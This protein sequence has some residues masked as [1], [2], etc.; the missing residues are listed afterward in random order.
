[1]FILD[2]EICFY[3]DIKIEVK[4]IGN[5]I[6][7]TFYGNNININNRKNLE[8]AYKIEY[9]FSDPDDAIKFMI[10][11]LKNNDFFNFIQDIK[12]LKKF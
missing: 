12:L 5:E 6:Q 11:S 2:N 3:G 1:M 4:N 9:V 8:K 10:V 7:L